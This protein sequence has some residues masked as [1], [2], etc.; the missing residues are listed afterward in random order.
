MITNLL[1]ILESIFLSNKSSGRRGVVVACSA[2]TLEVVSSN[3]SRDEFF[4]LSNHGFY[5]KFSPN[6]V[7]RIVNCRFSHN[8]AHQGCIWLKVIG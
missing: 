8:F 3:P 7:E 1:A 4:S 2:T 5:A 6:Y